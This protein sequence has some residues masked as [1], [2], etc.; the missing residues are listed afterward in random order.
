MPRYADFDAVLA[1]YP[2]RFN[3]EKASSMDDKVYMQLTGD[4]A[5]D[6]TLYVHHGEL[7]ILDGEVPEDPTLRLTAKTEDWVAIENGDLNPMMAMMQ[8]KVKM[9]GSVP[10]AT[11]FM[12][13]FGYGG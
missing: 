2:D 10:F 9:K 8:G 13:L 3:S 5:R 4:D 11:K 12:G 1:S 6:V 7:D